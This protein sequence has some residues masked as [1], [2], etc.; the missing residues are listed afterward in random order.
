MKRFAWMVPPLALAVL[1]TLGTL[2][3]K[4]GFM[5]IALATGLAVIAWSPP[6]L[7]L[8]I[9]FVLVQVLGN[10]LR[11]PGLPLAVPQ[12]SFL[13]VAAVACKYAYQHPK[14][15]TSPNDRLMVAFILLTAV[16]TAVGAAA[17]ADLSLIKED[18]APLAFL[19]ITYFAARVMVSTKRHVDLLIAAILL[20]TILAGLKL[21]YLAA[22][23]VQVSWDGPWQA[24]RI[25][26]DGLVVRLYLRGADVF[27]VAAVLLLVSQIF[28]RTQVT[29]TRVVAGVMSIWSIVVSGT[30][31]NMVG[32]LVGAFAMSFGGMSIAGARLRRLVLSAVLG[33]LVAVI[34]IAV[35]PSFRATAYR[36]WAQAESRSWTLSFR[37]FESKGVLNEV[38]AQH[39]LG[40]GLGATFVYFDLERKVLIRTGWTHNGPLM[41]LLK[42]G[43]QGL[44]LFGWIMGR[45]LID[46][47][48]LVRARHEWAPQVMGF[49][50]VIIAI[51]TLSV[52]INKIFDHSGA[53][54]LGLALAVIQTA[55]DDFRVARR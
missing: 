49:A 46:A 36:V 40:G 30:R 28:S 26:N 14:R 31:S 11:V 44:M 12:L 35:V 47:R 27:I 22:V 13:V 43:V 15:L 50:A 6:V 4:Y 7:L 2:M 38:S 29:V 51:L 41:V 23:P 3:P 5:A 39:G 34:A 16:A 54:L 24:T 52:P 33:L 48:R 18:L 9:P 19:W 45:A 42:L 20:G 32:L 17:G 21:A 55:A 25:L 1:V 8:G 10:G 53:M 37:E